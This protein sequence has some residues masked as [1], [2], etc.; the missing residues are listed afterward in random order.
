MEIR[1]LNLSAHQRER[2]LAAAE[3]IVTTYL[4]GG[5]CLGGTV[6]LVRLYEEC[7][8]EQE[9]STPDRTKD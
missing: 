6:D 8:N 3:S 4:S 9:T 5:D 2:I 1:Q 7:L